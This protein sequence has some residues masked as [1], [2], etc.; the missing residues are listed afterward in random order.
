MFVALLLVWLH[1]LAWVDL[2]A[3]DLEKPHIVFMLV[4]DWGWATIETQR[5]AWSRKVR[6]LTNTMS[7]SCALLHAARS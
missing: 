2:T 3:A 4:D 5:S 1:T 6:S 7:S